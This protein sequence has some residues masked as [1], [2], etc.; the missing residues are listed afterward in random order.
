MNY[1]ERINALHPDIINSFL[2]TKESVS[3]PR[4][5]QSYILQLQWSLEIWEHENERNISRAAR[6]LAI[7]S[8]AALKE[9]LSLT[10]AKE[11]IYAALIYFEV[12]CNVP[13]QI[14]DRDTA[15]KLEDLAKIAI[16]ADKFSVAEK[17]FIQANEFRRRANEVQEASDMNAPIILFSPDL[18]AEDLG[19][20]KENL[21]KIAKKASDGFYINLI[22]SLKIES[23][24]KQKLLKDADVEDVEFEEFANE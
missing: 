12:D 17:C 21:K 15:N 23:S 11:R 22:N 18:T 9:R 24:E 7:R 14:W 4:E 2:E 8:F 13:Q 1:L 20:G 5:L 19:F 10:A 3:I 6:K 16:D